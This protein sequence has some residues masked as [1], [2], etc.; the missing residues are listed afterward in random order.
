M[1]DTKRPEGMTDGSGLQGLRGNEPA[2]HQVPWLLRPGVAVALRTRLRVKVALILVVLIIP[3]VWLLF[4]T[5]QHWSRELLTLQHQRQGAE[6]LR[7]VAALAHTVHE[8]RMRASGLQF[9]LGDSG[10]VEQAAVQLQANVQQLHNATQAHASWDLASGAQ[11]LAQLVQTYL[12]ATTEPQVLSG[13]GALV[14]GLRIFS[15]QVADASSL[16]LSDDPRIYYQQDLLVE[17]LAPVINQVAAMSLVIATP[18]LGGG[19]QVLASLVQF[20]QQALLQRLSFLSRAQVSAPAQWAAVQ[21]SLEQLASNTA[22]GHVSDA[23]RFVLAQNGVQGLR[24]LELATETALAQE[25]EQRIHYRQ[26]RGMALLLLLILVALLSAY[27]VACVFVGISFMSRQIMHGVRN[28]GGGDLS[29]RLRYEARDDW[30]DMGNSIEV[31]LERLSSMVGQVR[32]S[33]ARLAQT[34][35]GL[36][37][38]TAALS[39]RASN[40]GESLQQTTTHVRRVS[41]TVARNA[42]ASQE[43]SLMTSSVHQEAQSAERLMRQAVAGLGPLQQ[44]SER[45]SEIIGSIDMIAFQTNLL[46]LNAAVEAARAGEQG[47]GFAVVAAEVRALA[48]RSQKAAA[49][50]RGLIRES[51]ERVATTVDEINQVD[52]LM[53]SLATGI[54]EIAMNINVMAENSAAQSSA[55]SEVVQAVGDLDQLTQENTAIIGRAAEHSDELLNQTLDLDAAVGFIHLRNGSADEARQLTIDA[56][57]HLHA[58][59]WEQAV[60]DFHDPAGRFIDRD[61]YIFSFDRSGRYRVFGSSPKRVGST[62]QVSPGIDGE[63]V[64]KSAWAVAD[65]GGGWTTYDYVSPTTA[66]IRPKSSYVVA[67][68]ADNLLGCGTYLLADIL[69]TGQSASSEDSSDTD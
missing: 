26:T 56:M 16:S 36:V 31:M 40:Q 39:Q 54:S 12:A 62:V 64:L 10:A 47:R 46:A 11:T 59:G 63:K 18:S 45:M 6:V 41:E 33:A 43:V 65:Q 22:S 25:L 49:E 66:E 42:D 35:R 13:Y 17:R 44:T 29:M 3:M 23:Q 28:A 24:A 19:E 1:A 53:G 68:D 52:I 34:G 37:E 61:L 4:E 30:G 48:G 67:V 32:A 9:Q 55:L 20:Q 51:A 21:T 5:A 2:M 7:S 58:V 15:A 60:H 69:N 57:V 50:V 8:H 38:D 14:R 27:L